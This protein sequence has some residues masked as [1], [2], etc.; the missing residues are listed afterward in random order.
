MIGTKVNTFK[1]S[2]PISDMDTLVAGIEAALRLTVLSTSYITGFRIDEAGH[3]VFCSQLH[4][5]QTLYPF[6]PSVNTLA[7]HIIDYITNI[8]EDSLIKFGEELTGYE[9]DYEIGFELYINDYRSDH[10]RIIDPSYHD[11]FAV[12]PIIIEEGK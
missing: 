12:K 6:K 4:K 11:I 1:I 2:G 8:D 5:H 9:E 7:D 10:L 3:L